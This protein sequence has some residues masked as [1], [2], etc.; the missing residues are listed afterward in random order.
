MKNSHILTFVNAIFL[1]YGEMV[2]I[3]YTT[4]QNCANYLT[5]VLSRNIYE[6][7]DDFGRLTKA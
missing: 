4:L 2:A 5:K 7:N 3:I 1:S 6:L